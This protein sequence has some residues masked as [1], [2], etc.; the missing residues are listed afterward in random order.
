LDELRAFR[1]YANYTVGGKLPGDKHYLNAIED[2]GRL[3]KQTGQA[4]SSLLCFVRAISDAPQA[5]PS[6]SERIMDTIGDDIGDDVYQMYLSHADQE[7]V[8]AYL[9]AEKLTT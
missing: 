2:S 3:Y 7:R 9:L 5:T 8:T 4:M 1:E 6:I